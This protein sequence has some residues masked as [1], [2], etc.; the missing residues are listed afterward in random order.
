MPSLYAQVSLAVRYGTVLLYD[1]TAVKNRYRLPLGLGVVIDGEYFTRIVFQTITADTRAD[2]FVWMLEAFKEARGGPPGVFIQDADAAMTQAA[3]RVFPLATK[4]RCLWHLGQNLIKNM[5]PTLGSDFK[6]SQTCASYNGGWRVTSL[7]VLFCNKRW[8]RANCCGP[9]RVFWHRSRPTGVVGIACVMLPLFVLTFCYLDQMSEISSFHVSYRT[10]LD[11]SV[12]LVTSCY[13]PVVPFHQPAQAF[14]DLFYT[15]QGR[16]SQAGF[17]DEYTKL[18]ETFPKSKRYM[19]GLYHDRN[20]W[21][22]YSS[23]LVFSVSSFTT[24]RVECEVTL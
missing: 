2:T 13:Q 5:K 14:L 10:E 7:G 17:E 6:V 21:A 19:D 9:L 1:D 24:N 12:F 20:R 8:R 15:M 23:V 22:M 16:L 11:A 18:V 3:E 4:R